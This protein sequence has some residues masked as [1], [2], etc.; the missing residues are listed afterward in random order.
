M[1]VGASPSG[2]QYDHTFVSAEINSLKKKRDRHDT[3]LVITS[4]NTTD[5]TITV[6]VNCPFDTL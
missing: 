4:I 2:Q 6:N 1:N 5:G 3:P